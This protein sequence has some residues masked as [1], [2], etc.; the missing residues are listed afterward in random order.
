MPQ[1]PPFLQD[2]AF[3]ALCQG[4]DQDLADRARAEG[5]P[6]CNGRLD[7]AHYPRKPRGLPSSCQQYADAHSG[8]RDHQDRAIVITAIGIVIGAKRRW[9][10][11]LLI[12]R[13]LPY[14]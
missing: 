4:L 14:R 6:I 8:H 10:V 5:C 13:V 12:T 9:P 3:Y 11:S 7:Q 1:I 2:P